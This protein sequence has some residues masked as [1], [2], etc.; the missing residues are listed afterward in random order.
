MEQT[1]MM[2]LQ[3]E[4]ARKAERLKADLLGE[5]FKEA[6]DDHIQALMDTPLSDSDD[7]VAIVA[8]M[9]ANLALEQSL[10]SIVQSGKM[11]AKQ[12][13]DSESLN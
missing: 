1:D 11:S 13:A 5:Y 9:K 10:E 3:V 2:H 12:L 6:L 8:S 4:L 7:I